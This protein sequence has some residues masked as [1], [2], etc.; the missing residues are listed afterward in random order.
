[1][2]QGKEQVVATTIRKPAH[3]QD[4]TPEQ[5]W[6]AE[7]VRQVPAEWLADESGYDERAWPEVKRGLEESR[8]SSRR[9]LTTEVMLQVGTFWARA[10]QAGMTTAPDPALDLAWYSS[11]IKR[12]CPVETLASASPGPAA[13]VPNPALLA[14]SRLKSARSAWQVGESKRQGTSDGLLGEGGVGEHAQ[15]GGSGDVEH[16]DR[17]ARLPFHEYQQL[18]GGPQ[19]EIEH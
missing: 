11:R 9:L 6:R 17:Y 19:P 18:G 8:T 4:P 2:A 12:G 1:M 10:H 13:T 14:S 7:G 16:L 15:G 5:R 3:P